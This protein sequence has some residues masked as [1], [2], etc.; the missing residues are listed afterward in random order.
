MD[1]TLKKGGSF[2]GEMYRDVKIFRVHQMH[3]VVGLYPDRAHT[4]VADNNICIFWY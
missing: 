1:T 2:N 3:V 4:P